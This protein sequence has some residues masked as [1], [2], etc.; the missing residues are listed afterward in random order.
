M[1]TATA[2]IIITDAHGPEVHRDV[3][4][5]NL[6]DNQV[7]QRTARNDHAALGAASS[8]TYTR[9]GNAVEPGAY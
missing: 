9:S 1:T 5:P 3:S 8:C 7:R 2:A 6:V 4:V